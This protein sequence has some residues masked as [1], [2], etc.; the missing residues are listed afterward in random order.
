M[1][2][3]PWQ[4]NTWIWVVYVCSTLAEEYFSQRA[5]YDHHAREKTAQFAGKSLDEKRTVWYSCTVL[6]MGLLDDTVVSMY[7]VVHVCRSC[8][9]VLMLMILLQTI[10]SVLSLSPCS[11]T[12]AV[13]SP[14]GHTYERSAIEQHLQQTGGSGRD[15]LTNRNVSLQEL[16]PNS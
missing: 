3:V 7:C 4:L 1:R 8:L 16:L 14:S 11:P 12:L 2:F 9:A 10:S 6:A 13:L 5:M 15:P